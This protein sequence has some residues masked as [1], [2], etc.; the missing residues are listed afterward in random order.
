MQNSDKLNNRDFSRNR[1]CTR[2]FWAEIASNAKIL[3]LFSNILCN[4]FWH[5]NIICLQHFL[6]PLNFHLKVS[7]LVLQCPVLVLQI[8]TLLL[9]LD[10]LHFLLCSAP[11]RRDIVQVPLPSLLHDSIVLSSFVWH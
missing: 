4:K 7:C 6:E 3:N 8:S 11:L 9:F 1:V 5:W 2:L 10:P